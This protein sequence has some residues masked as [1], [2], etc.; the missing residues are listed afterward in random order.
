MWLK[1]VLV[2]LLVRRDAS[3]WL[4]VQYISISMPGRNPFLR[5]LFIGNTPRSG[6]LAHEYSLT[7]MK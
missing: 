6:P 7:A 2:V 3:R 1:L 4:D 5:P